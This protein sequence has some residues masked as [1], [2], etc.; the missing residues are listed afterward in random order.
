[1]ASGDFAFHSRYGFGCICF[2]EAIGLAAPEE[3]IERFSSGLVCFFGLEYT[4][5]D[6]RLYELWDTGL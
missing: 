6:R 3:G 2:C 4:R 1:M 5:F